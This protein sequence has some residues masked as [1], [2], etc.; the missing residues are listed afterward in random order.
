MKKENQNPQTPAEAEEFPVMKRKADE[1]PAVA[2]RPTKVVKKEDLLTRKKVPITSKTTKGDAS[3]NA[4]VNQFSTS[5][6]S[7]V[8]FKILFYSFS[9]H[10][11]IHKWTTSHKY[12]LIQ[13]QAT[14]SSRL[15][16]SMRVTSSSSTL[17]S[18]FRS[19]TAAAP[20]RTA[21]S[22]RSNSNLNVSV[23]SVKPSG[24]RPAW[25]LKV[26]ITLLGYIL[27]LHHANINQGRLE[28]MEAQLR[29]CLE[30]NDQLGS[31]VS[32][33]HDKVGEK[34]QKCKSS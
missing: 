25:D 7:S 22:A 9:V 28:D 21:L 10:T 8:S 33:L 24:K 6:R 14:A 34:E 18:S 17:N 29:A 31:Q 13:H 3:L 12:T 4:K 15:N 2:D 16:Q 11:L 26:Y 30:K 23:A 27:L 5:L 20:K 32:T 1:T 19:T